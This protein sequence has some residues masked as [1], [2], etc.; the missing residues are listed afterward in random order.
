[1]VKEVRRDKYLQHIR[2]IGIIAHIDAG[3]TTLTERIL[4]Y[5]KKI[6]RMGEVHDGTAT[7]D[8]MPEEQERGITITSATTSCV[9]K[10]KQINI[11]D[12]PGHVD[13]TI[14]VERSL[15]VL[16]GAVGVFCAVGGVEAQSENV[17]RQSEH[18]HV[19]KL[20]FI[21]KMDRLG[22]DFQ[23]VIQ[24]MQ[25]K[26][27]I[28][29]LVL[30]IPW[31][32]GMDFSGII[33][34]LGMKLLY[35]DP[36]SKGLEMQSSDLTQEQLDYALPWREGLVENLSEFDEDLMEQYLNGEEIPLERLMAVIRQ[37]TLDLNAVPIFVGAAL[38]NSGIQP[39]LDGICHYLPSPLE[40]SQV[41]GIDPETKQEISFP[42]DSSAPLS[43]LVFK[44]T[45]ESGRVLSLMRIYSGTIQAGESVYNV[46]KGKMQRI[47]RLFTLHAGH[48]E[49][50]ET[51]KTGQIVAAAGLKEA[52]TGD[53]LSGKEKPIL[54]E[55][56]GEYK[57]V[58][59]LALEPRNTAEEEKLLEALSKMLQEDPTLE[60]KR[61]EDTEQIILS[62]MGELHLEIVLDRLQREYKVGMRAGNPQVV[63]RET[64][65]GQAQANDEFSRELGDA[66]HFG[67]VSLAVEPLARDKENQIIFETDLTEFPSNWVDAVYQ[68]VEDGLQS[69]VLKGY[70]VQGVMV[71]IVA[72]GKDPNSSSQVGYHLAANGALKKAMSQAQPRLMEPIMNVEVCVPEDFVGDVVS[73]LGGKGSKI[74]N[75]FDRGGGKVVQ[76]LTPLKQMFGFSTELRSATQGRGT[77][78]MKFER[79]D[80]LE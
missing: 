54:L 19:P 23:S 11:I 31:G 41:K 14:E 77:F 48:K 44:V 73:L 55:K 26:L 47:A 71:K 67:S 27:N 4:Y 5:T 32:Q 37:V 49:R 12:T 66:L 28:N 38:K 74:D 46:T 16:D 30:Q 18:Y 68:G 63:Y 29:P 7:M 61:D 10:N 34:L 59:S 33:D 43:A 65:A 62:G 24:D 17:W 80:V 9:W 13:F 45:M 51:A 58:M 36:Q 2:N 22:A 64:L 15:R 57:P 52:R 3:K 50:L 42:I 25:D 72:L 20:A 6:H 76:A 70:P 39:V 1:M 8:F 69:G 35:F 79:F 40:V 53:T 60:L 21:N 56:I 75:M 78:M